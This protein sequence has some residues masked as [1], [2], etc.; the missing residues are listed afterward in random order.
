MNTGILPFRF[1][2]QA[3]FGPAA[4]TGCWRVLRYS[5]RQATLGMPA[6]S[7]RSEDAAREV[8][9]LMAGRRPWVRVVLEDPEGKERAIWAS[10]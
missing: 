3:R 9:R 2:R 1:A 5:S 8:F 4:G 7:G 6:Y 10:R